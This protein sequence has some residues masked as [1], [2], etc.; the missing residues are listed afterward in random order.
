MT[1]RIFLLVAN[2]IGILALTAVIIGQWLRE[3]DSHARFEKQADRLEQTATRLD[4]ETKR[5]G[6]LEADVAQLK[7]A[8]HAS[9]QARQAAEAELAKIIAERDTNIATANQIT[10]QANASVEAAADKVAAWEK[11]VSERDGRIRSL[12]ADL[13]ATRKRLDEAIA[14]LKQAGA[15]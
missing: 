9:V 8:V 6:A 13:T 1:T 5:A 4:D 14:E 12:T 2:L 7:E 15:R 3:R 11:A 10:G